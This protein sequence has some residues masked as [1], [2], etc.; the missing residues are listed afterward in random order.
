[1]RNRLL[2][3][4][5]HAAFTLFLVST[6]YAQDNGDDVYWHIDSSVK[7]CSMVIDPTLTQA[8]WGKFTEQVGAILTYKSLASAEP[9]GKMNFDIGID[10]SY[11]PVDQHDPAW[12]NTFTHPDADCPLGDAITY[13]TVRARMGVSDNT[14]VGVYWI[15]APD[16]NYG[17][18]GGELKHAFLQESGNLPA[19]AVKGERFSADWSSRLQSECL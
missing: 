8:Q 5:L 11:T 7:S 4:T 3:G 14:D 12:I 9:L 13:P 15:T 19:A 2:N 1:M 17:M 18:V 10:N 16:A 6:S